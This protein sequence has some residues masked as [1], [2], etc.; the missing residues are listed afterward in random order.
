MLRSDR[1]LG[2]LLWLRSGQAVSAIELARRF[3]VSVRTIYRDVDTLSALGVPVY[4]VRGRG[5]GFRLLEGYFLPAIAFTRDEAVS[6]VVGLTILRRLR[7]RPLGDALETAQAKLLAAMPAH[8]GAVLAGAARIVGFEALPEDVFHPDLP[9]SSAQPERDDARERTAIDV[10]L[11]AILD[12]R[13][14]RLTYRAPYRREARTVVALPQGMFWDNDRWYLAGR[15]LDGERPAR[16]WRADR[17]VGISDLPDPCPEMP[18]FDVR[19]LLGRAWL[20]TAMTSWAEESPVRLRLTTEQAD[21]LRR[22]W[23]YGHA[24]FEPCA[25]GRVTMTFGNDDLQSVLALLR[26]L[27]PGAELLEPA[28]WR[29]ELRA[30]LARMLS[31]HTDPAPA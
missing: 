13:A 10:F 27:G 19:A 26:W 2:I 24:R 25:D 16:L 29:A 9:A 21:R 8:L 6:L 18:P 28:A 15:L 3:E 11:R 20:A 22:D 31:D 4:A 14:L 7:T 17:V 5:G 12:G 1:L 30:E 23:Y